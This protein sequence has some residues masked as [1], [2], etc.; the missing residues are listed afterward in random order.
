MIP[1][2][3]EKVLQ[4]MDSDHTE[5]VDATLFPELYAMFLR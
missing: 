2:N 1:H 4:C 5:E 3:T